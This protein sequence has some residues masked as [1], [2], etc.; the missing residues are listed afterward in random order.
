VWRVL[1]Q[2]RYVAGDGEITEDVEAEVVVLVGEDVADVEVVLIGED[3]ADDNTSMR[4]CGVRR[5]GAEGF[6]EGLEVAA[7]HR[8]REQ[9]GMVWGRTHLEHGGMRASRGDVR[10]WEKQE[11]VGFMGFF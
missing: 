11:Q 7:K 2:Q 8:G 4:G 6:G 5:G 1:L 9:G 10:D 3:V